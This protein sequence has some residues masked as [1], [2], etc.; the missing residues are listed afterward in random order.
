MKG[1]LRHVAISVPDIEAAAQFYEKTFG[2]ERINEVQTNHGN[3]I[4]LSD[5]V[6]NLTVLN[7]PTDES[8]GDERGKDFVGI[9]HMG[10]VVEDLGAASEAVVA[11]GGRYHKEIGT[12]DDFTGFERKYRD[13]NGIVIDISRTWVGTTD[14]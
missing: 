5:G 10:F 7:F 14:V 9:H 13:P 6:V 3:G 11:Q 12:E 2:M 8:A 1:K 4:S